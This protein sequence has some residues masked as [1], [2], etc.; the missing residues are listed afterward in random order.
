MKLLRGNKWEVNFSR[1]GGVGGDRVLVR[2]LVS[3]V[4][5]PHPAPL[6]EALR[7]ALGPP[8]NVRVVLSTGV[9][10]GFP[11]KKRVR[12][13]WRRSQGLT[14]LPSAIEYLFPKERDNLSSNAPLSPPPEFL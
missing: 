4:G 5:R 7:D 1:P 10:L 14:S 13:L 12:L 6:V 3:S 2:S 11:D 9:T 8:V